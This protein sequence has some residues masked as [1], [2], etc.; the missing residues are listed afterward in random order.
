VPEALRPALTPLLATLTLLSATIAGYDRQIAALIRDTCPAAQ[1]L[2]QPAGVGPLTALAMVLLLDGP[3]RF[4]TSRAVGAYF[5]LV[6]RVDESG[7]LTPQLRITKA[8]DGMGRRLVVSAAQYAPDHLAQRRSAAA[9]NARGRPASPSAAPAAPA[10][11]SY[12]CVQPAS[13]VTAIRALAF[14]AAAE[15]AAPPAPV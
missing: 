10:A 14:E 1:R 15:L 6:P 5:G 3:A 9:P 8:G 2:Q 7:T 4:P 13:V 12:P 11:P